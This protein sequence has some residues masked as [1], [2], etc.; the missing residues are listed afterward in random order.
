MKEKSSA[1]SD[2]D[3][4]NKKIESL[5][6]I[7]LQS[8][9]QHFVSIMNLGLSKVRDSLSCQDDSLVDEVINAGNQT[10][11]SLKK[12]KKLNKQDFLQV[13]WRAVEILDRLTGKQFIIKLSSKTV[14]VGV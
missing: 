8:I 13:L 2:L 12:Y 6:I 7:D 14:E 9:D 10:F 4:F 3:Y 1:G 11:F 5:M